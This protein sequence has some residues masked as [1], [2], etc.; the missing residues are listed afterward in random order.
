MDYNPEVSVCED[1]D[2]G[3]GKCVVS[4]RVP[5]TDQ[6]KCL[7]LT[8]GS[9]SYGAREDEPPPTPASG[10]QWPRKPDNREGIG[11]LTTTWTSDL[12]GDCHA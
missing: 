4:L 7:R 12:H 5:Q 6:G 2:R 9:A 3:E 10:G 1:T 11:R 8:R